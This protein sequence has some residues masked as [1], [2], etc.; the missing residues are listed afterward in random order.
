MRM[1]RT[2]QGDTWDLVALRMYP[3]LG[4]EKLM[5]ALL[6]QNPAHRE[7]VIFEANVV[8]QIP[9]VDVPVVSTLPPWKCKGG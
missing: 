9:D 3:D 4:G 6:Q 1:Y 7:T 5:H 8:L 2:A